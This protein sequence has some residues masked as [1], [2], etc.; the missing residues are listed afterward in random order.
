[1]SYCSLATL[2]FLRLEG[3]F[4]TSWVEQKSIVSKVQAP[5]HGTLQHLPTIWRFSIH[6]K[7]DPIIFQ[8]GTPNHDNNISFMRSISSATVERWEYSVPLVKTPC[9]GCICLLIYRWHLLIAF[10]AS[11]DS[12][13][14]TEYATPGL[15]ISYIKCCLYDLVHYFAVNVTNDSMR[16]LSIWIPPAPVTRF[17]WCLQV[18]SWDS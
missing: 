10:H 5:R 3:A 18:Q 13:D 14:T 6:L 9:Y 17:L 15:F 8:L 1:M 11:F 4:S 12:H 2:R 16:S 7:I